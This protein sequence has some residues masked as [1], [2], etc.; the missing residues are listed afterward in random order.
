M[1]VQA[2]KIA[3]LASGQPACTGLHLLN[4][5]IFEDFDFDAATEEHNPCAG[6]LLS[7]RESETE[8]ASLCAFSSEVRQFCPQDNLIFYS[9]FKRPQK[10]RQ[11]ASYC[12]KLYRLC[13][14]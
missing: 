4:G 11:Q 5:N 6:A 12:L 3:T 2:G 8:T 1:E 14:F 10:I 13:R 7:R 9:Y